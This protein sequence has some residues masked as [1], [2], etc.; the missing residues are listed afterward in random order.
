MKRS[1]F[2]IW[3]IFEMRDRRLIPIFSLC[4]IWRDRD[5]ST[6]RFL[7]SQS[8]THTN[9][10]QNRWI[11]SD[12]YF[13]FKYHKL[14]IYMF[15]LGIT[16]KCI[17]TQRHRRRQK[18][19]NLLMAIG[20]FCFFF[21]I[22]WHNFF[23]NMFVFFVLRMLCVFCMF[24]HTCLVYMNTYT[25]YVQCARAHGRLWSPF[26]VAITAVFP[27]RS[28]KIN[29]NMAMCASSNKTVE[30]FH[31]FFLFLYKEVSIHA[32]CVYKYK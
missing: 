17:N 23:L 30:F 28:A 20:E 7:L 2:S 16:I 3:E 14:T 26:M 11:E 6:V 15:C 25:L 8:S 9:A 19:M 10:N 5:L 32:C 22:K 29:C 1:Y 24:A 18:K 13:K 4:D 31:V 21:L 27:V 12:I